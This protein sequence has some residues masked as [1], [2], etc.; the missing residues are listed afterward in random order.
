MAD[1]VVIR[2]PDAPALSGRWFHIEAMPEIEFVTGDGSVT[3]V[4]TPF[5]ET[6]EDGAVAQVYMRKKDENG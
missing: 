4:P 3:Y 1:L 5:I 6:R 2:D